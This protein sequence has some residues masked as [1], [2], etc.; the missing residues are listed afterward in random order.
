[1]VGNLYKLAQ[2]RESSERRDRPLR[3]GLS[4]SFIKFIVELTVEGV[5]SRLV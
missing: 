3:M 4:S 1:M 2:L 5:L